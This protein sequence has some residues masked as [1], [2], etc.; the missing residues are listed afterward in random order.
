[1]V[2]RL[3]P[4][5]EGGLRG[6]LQLFARRTFLKGFSDEEADAIIDEVVD[7]CE[8]DMK[9]KE[10]NWA[11]MYIRLRFSATLTRAKELC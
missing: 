4:L 9:D 6:W 8:V 1:L 11:L 2:P 10:G 7:M 3:T 5:L